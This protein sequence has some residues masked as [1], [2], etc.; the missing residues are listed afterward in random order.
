MIGH[1]GFT[2]TEGILALGIA[3]II[4]G[5]VTGW[6]RVMLNPLRTDSSEF[7]TALTELEQAGRF[8]VATVSPQSLVLVDHL[9]AKPTAGEKRVAITVD[10]QGVLKLTNPHNR[11]YSPL[12]R[13]VQQ[14]RFARTRV[15][16]LIRLKIKR[17]GEAWQSTLLDFREPGP[18]S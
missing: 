11:G 10:H 18:A 8:T 9:P 7:Y 2:L 12:L 14:L 1:R 15:S 13:H 6:S 4:L 5:L 17:E 16:G 3:A